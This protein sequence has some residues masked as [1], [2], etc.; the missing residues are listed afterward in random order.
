MGSKGGDREVY[1]FLTTL[2]YGI[3][4]GPIDA[5]NEITI[6]DRSALQG[7]ISTRQDVV[8][9]KPDLFGGD[10]GEGGPQGTVEV[11]IGDDV[12]T[13]STDMA[14]RVGLT[15][16]TMPGYRG[17]AHLFFRGVAGLGFNWTSNNPYLPPAKVSVTRTPVGLSADQRVWPIIG[18]DENGDYILAVEGDAF[19]VA[20]EVDRTKLPDTNGAA[21]LYEL[22]TNTVWGKGEPLAEMNTD[23]YETCAATLKAEHFGMSMKFMRQDSVEKFTAE[24]LDHIKAVQYQDPATGLWTLKLIRGDYD[25]AWL[26]T[27]DPSNCTAEN[28]K[29]R[30]WGETISQIVVS[31]TDPVSEKP[32]TVEAQ[33]SANIAI[34]GGLSSEERDYYA[35]RNPYL[36]KELADRDVAESSRALTSATIYA[37]QLASNLVP[38]GVLILTWPEEEILKM[39][40]R[41]AKIDY[42]TAKD[43]RV[44]I[45]VVEDVFATP[46]FGVAT[47]PQAALGQS[48]DPQPVDP[49]RVFIMTPPLPPML[50]QGVDPDDLDLNY[51]RSFA[52]FMVGSSDTPFVTI[53]AQAQ[54]TLGNGTVGVGS[55][56]V[57]RPTESRALGVV[58]TPEIRSVIGGDEIF[59]LL[60]GNEAV[61]D[62]LVIGDS[63]ANHEIVMLD[64]FDDGA[65][66]WTVLRAVYDT[67]PGDWEAT[68][69]LWVFPRTLD[70]QER[71]S[72]SAVAY[73]FLPRTVLGS[74]LLED[75]TAHVFTPD[76]RPHRPFRPAFVT[77][78]GNAW[79]ADTQFLGGTAPATITLTWRDRNRLGEDAVAMAWDD[80]AATPEPGQTTTIRF[81][82]SDTLELEYEETD[83]TGGTADIDLSNLA[84]FRF[85][86]V[87]FVAVRDGI[88][89][90]RATTVKLE[91]EQLGYGNNYGFDYGEN[92]GDV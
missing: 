37:D 89:S 88:E 53:D 38:G 43:R 83:L 90:F 2:D 31:F 48:V 81:R 86:D 60:F 56:A 78:D 64:S 50:S 71:V 69:L 4:H 75:S 77:V 3:C 44:K 45:D 33:N 57:F 55:V 11:Y 92:D 17:L 24:V 46:S 51:P 73:N 6:K 74:L 10:E 27:F 85:Y 36:A 42:G 67:L 18:I 80:I 79:D 9:A 13:A 59:S 1:D 22:M 26:P 5:L 32:E 30:L 58:F 91:I 70:G 54:K 82:S 29:T 23:S 76:D 16:S 34:Q 72:G 20:G 19:A 84:N 41:V 66:E 68:D 14:A 21:I 39:A 7:P 8:I 47:A 49:D 62:L 28:I 65:N 87:E 40:C 61:G 25:V 35:V 12:Q 63:D 15:P 52:A